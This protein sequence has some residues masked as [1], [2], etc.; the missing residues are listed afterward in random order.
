VLAVVG[1]NPPTASS[2]AISFLAAT[3]G[4]AFL[5][6]IVGFLASVV[7]KRVDEP[8]IEISLTV[9]AAYGSFIAA[10]QVHTSGVIATV[11]AGLVF[12]TY[13]RQHG[14]SVASRSAVISFWEYVAFAMNS[15][16]FL[17]I[18][19]DTSLPTLLQYWPQIV[20]AFGA[21]IAAR[22]LIVF[23]AALLVRRTTERLPRHWPLV[24]SWGGI[25]GALSVVLALGVPDSFGNRDQLLAM[26]IGVVVLSILVQGV[27]MSPLLR[28]L[29]IAEPSTSGALAQSA[30]PTLD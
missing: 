28:V 5:G 22:M 2:L 16:V 12:G 3:L 6:G 27:T 15:I 25:R 20:I 30:A 29:Q 9:I 4:G 13:G 1:G 8:M 19:F 24:I 26:T 21:M 10:E 18:G 7:L 17:L 11:A 23:V 14:M